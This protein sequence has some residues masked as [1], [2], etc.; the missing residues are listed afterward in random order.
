MG[1]EWWVAEGMDGRRHVVG[2]ELLLGGEH[3]LGVE[4]QGSST[5]SGFDVIVRLDASGFRILEAMREK[6]S[7]QALALLLDRKVMVAPLSAL[8]IS[9]DRILVARG[10]SATEAKE[11]AFILGAPLVVP[12]QTKGQR[13]M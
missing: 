6:T 5:G 1:S 4:T 3:V 9:G 12:L 13:G 2:E 11:L 7:R 10:V 8:A